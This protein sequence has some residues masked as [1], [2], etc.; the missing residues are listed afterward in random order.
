MNAKELYQKL[1]TDFKLNECQDDWS[2][3][4]F[5]LEFITENF[6]KRYI[7]ILADNTEKINKVYT[8]V[9]PLE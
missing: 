5:D 1:E 6:R 2:N 7:G 8:A 4:E 3:I 9:F